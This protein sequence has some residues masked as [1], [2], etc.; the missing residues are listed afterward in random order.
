VWGIGYLSAGGSESSFYTYPGLNILVGK[1]S[2]R[3]IVII[4]LES[5][6]ELADGG[7]LTVS[8]N[9]KWTIV[10]PWF[11]WQSECFTDTRT[12]R[13]TI[14]GRVETKVV[15]TMDKKESCPGVDSQKS[16]VTAAAVSRDGK[17]YAMVRARRSY[18]TGK[19]E[20]GLIKLFNSSDDKEI[21]S[22]RTSFPRDFHALS[23]TMSGKYLVLEDSM[24]EAKIKKDLWLR[25]TQ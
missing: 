2:R 10:P 14:Q 9:G 12:F 18:E 6:K 25:I 16:G 3:G 24:E 13:I 21:A 1:Q 23:F 20:D 19:T 8:P 4:D 15:D 22:L 11:S 5:G 7:D 17:L